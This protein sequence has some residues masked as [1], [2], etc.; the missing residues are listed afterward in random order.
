MGF[1]VYSN[2]HGPHITSCIHNVMCT[3]TKDISLVTCFIIIHGNW[4]VGVN[5]KVLLLF[6]TD[7][8][9]GVRAVPAVTSV[10][11][12]FVLFV[13]LQATNN[14][15]WKLCMLYATEGD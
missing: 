8:V 12:H 11:N 1:F 15:A 7:S 10:E 14:Y 6:L 5:R 2:N 4:L 3:F 9:P 13:S